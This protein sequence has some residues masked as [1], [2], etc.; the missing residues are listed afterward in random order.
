ML[1]HGEGYIVG[2]LNSLDNGLNRSG[3]LN[4]GAEK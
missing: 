3:L 4:A 1:P 2:D